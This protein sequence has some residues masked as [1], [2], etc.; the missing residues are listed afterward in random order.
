[1]KYIINNQVVLSQAPEGPLTAHI[2]SFTEF[3]SAQGYA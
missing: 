2:D 3:I 1:M